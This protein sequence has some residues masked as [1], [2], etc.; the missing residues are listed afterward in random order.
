M[1][2]VNTGSNHNIE[3]N[4]SEM[5]GQFSNCAMP[6]DIATY[7]LN[8]LHFQPNFSPN[9]I[10]GAGNVYVDVWSSTWGGTGNYNF[11]ANPPII[12][13]SLGLTNIDTTTTFIMTMEDAASGCASVSDT[14]TVIVYPPFY[15]VLNDTTACEW[16]FVTLSPILIGGSSPYTYSWSNGSTQP[17]ASYTAWASGISQASVQIT[18][19][20]GCLSSDYM[21]IATYP[22]PPIP[23]ITAANG[24]VTCSVPNMASYQ[25]FL[26]GQPL[27][28]ETS[29][30]IDS[31]LIGIY[32]VVV[33]NQYGCTASSDNVYVAVEEFQAFELNVSPNPTEK[34]IQIRWGD[35]EEKEVEISLYDTKNALLL[36]EMYPYIQPNSSQFLNVETYTEGI[37]ILCIKSAKRQ[38]MLKI[39]KY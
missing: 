15:T 16:S 21:Q 8:N 29:Q 23:V 5:T 32:S 9:P 17:T 14:V 10:C 25:W 2:N 39:V 20:N 38:K 24:I 34:Q 33:T 36:H 7:N 22:I 4:V 27:P 37:Y 28:N 11:T 19:A 31:A 1:S 26:N 30:Q 12:D 6:S 35:I 3:V 18:D 13:F